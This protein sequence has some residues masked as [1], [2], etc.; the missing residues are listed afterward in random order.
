MK[1]LT[2]EARQQVRLLQGLI[3]AKQLEVEALQLGLEHFIEKAAGVDLVRQHWHL[4]PDTGL[5]MR[6]AEKTNGSHPGK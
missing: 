1:Q 2:P 3:Q 4:D 5:L 6:S